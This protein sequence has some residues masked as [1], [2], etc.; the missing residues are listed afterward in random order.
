MFIIN[1]T[2]IIFFIDL[3]RVFG[4][5]LRILHG[6]RPLIVVPHPSIGPHVRRGA[7]VA[8]IVEAHRLKNIISFTFNIM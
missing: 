7:G 6:V 8:G 5:G 4:H 1:I 2:I 3:L